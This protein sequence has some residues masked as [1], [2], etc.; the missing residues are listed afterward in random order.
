MTAEPQQPPEDKPDDG[1][2]TEQVK[3]QNITARVPES[4]SNGVF[5]TG[6]IVMT[7]ANEFILD[8]L[9]IVGR[10]RQIA[11]RIVMPHG[12]MPQF[13]DALHKN[14]DIYKQRFGTPPEPPKQPQQNRPS[15]QEIY[16]DLKLP[17]ELLPGSYANGV[18]ISH[19]ASEFNFDFLTNFF[20]HSAVSSRVFMSAPQVVKMLE[21]LNTTYQQFVQ[22]VNEQRAAQGQPPLQ[23]PPQPPPGDTNNPPEPPTDNGGA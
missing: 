16:D 15:I 3:M 6:V 14:I 5:S 12:A 9:Q 7:G 1:S 10:P 4:V 13:I 17:D 2:R 8:F 23:L 11:A 21:S 18:M 22:R 20:P 19:A